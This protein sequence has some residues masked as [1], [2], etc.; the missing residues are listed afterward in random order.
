VRFL[1]I[2]LGL[3]R[4]GLAV[5]DTSATL[6]RPLVT[7]TLADPGDVLDRVS[8]EV[9]RLLSE[10]DG[11]DGVVVGMPS[12]LDGSRTEAT[13]RS[14]AFVAALA[15]RVSVPV[16]TGDE[17]LTSRE[18][19]SRL[20]LRERDWRRR[21]ALLDAAAAAVILQDFLDARQQAL[22]REARDAS[23]RPDV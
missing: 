1:G 9:V 11:L 20:A 18:A 13:A 21:K 8:A 15:A 6:A 12:A 17:R 4:V 7:L 19:E 5:S 3:R 14:E 22:A 16:K 23:I 10:E 2:D